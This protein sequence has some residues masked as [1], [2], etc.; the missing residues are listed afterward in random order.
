MSCIQAGKKFG[1]SDVYPSDRTGRRRRMLDAFIIDQLRRER[2]KNQ[3]E[4]IPL[5]LPLPMHAPCPDSSDQG[6]ANEDEESDRGIHIVE[7]Y[8][9]HE[10]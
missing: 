6:P 3:W 2:E 5:H 1:S 9:T 8:G 7:I 10:P 4:P